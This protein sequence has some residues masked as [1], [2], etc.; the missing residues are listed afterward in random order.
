MKLARII[1][2][3]HGTRWELRAGKRGAGQVLHTCVGV[4]PTQP[5]STEHAAACLYAEAERQGYAIEEE[6]F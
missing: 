5:K 2:K 3:E 1:Q 6:E 4:I